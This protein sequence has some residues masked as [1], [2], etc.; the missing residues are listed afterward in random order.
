MPVQLIAALARMAGNLLLFAA[1]WLATPRARIPSITLATTNE[2]AQPDE[3]GVLPRVRHWTRQYKL[4]IAVAE[5]CRIDEF[6]PAHCIECDRAVATTI[7][8]FETNWLFHFLRP[9]VPPL[10]VFAM[11]RRQC[12]HDD[13]HCLCWILWHRRQMK[14]HIVYVENIPIVRIRT[15]L[16][17]S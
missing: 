8:A 15:H 16:F 5:I 17:F 9:A 12:V 4:N 3:A 7:P 11:K 1:A 6:V 14:C 10:W 13:F 2:A